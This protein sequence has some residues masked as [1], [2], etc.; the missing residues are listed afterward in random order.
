MG[1]LDTHDGLCR[2]LAAATGWTV[3]AVDYRLSPEHRYPAALD[4]LENA[5]DWSR[6]RDIDRFVF[7]SSSMVYGNFKT[8][9][10]DEDHPLDPIGIYG[11]LKLAGEKLVIAYNSL[12]ELDGILTARDIIVRAANT[13]DLRLDVP[14]L[15]MAS[16]TPIE[17]STVD[18]SRQPVRITVT[19]ENERLVDSRVTRP[20]GTPTTTPVDLPPGAYSITAGGLNPGSQINP[21]STDVLVW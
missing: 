2:H 11:A 4:D 14:D 3:L 6:N 13:V 12:D 20:T 5:L 10:V 18:G 21:V 1:D 16:S 8:D 7:F 9:E 17:V 19:D 15:V